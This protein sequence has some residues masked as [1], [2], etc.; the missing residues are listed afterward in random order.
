MDFYKNHVLPNISQV[1]FPGEYYE[2]IQGNFDGVKAR[3]VSGT[4]YSEIL[5][6]EVNFNDAIALNCMSAFAFRG[7][8]STFSAWD[9]MTHDGAVLSLP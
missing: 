9:D 4:I 3:T 6:R 7:M 8:C 2:E 1:H 5:G